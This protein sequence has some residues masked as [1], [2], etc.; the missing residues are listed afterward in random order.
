MK[1]IQKI[2]IKNRFSVIKNT[3]NSLSKLSISSFEPT[4]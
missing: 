1:K 3:A 2:S 4:I